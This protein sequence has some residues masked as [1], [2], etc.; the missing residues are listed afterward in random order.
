MIDI[1]MKYFKI[2]FYFINKY[3][4]F[5]FSLTWFRFLDFFVLKGLVALKQWRV[6]LYVYI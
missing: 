2:K 5:L 3:K 1:K 6:C 4:T